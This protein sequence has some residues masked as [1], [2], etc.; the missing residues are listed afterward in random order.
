MAERMELDKKY[1]MSTLKRLCEGKN[2]EVQ[3]FYIK[4]AKKNARKLA[5]KYGLEKS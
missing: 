5:E 4:V 1:L 2:K 3:K